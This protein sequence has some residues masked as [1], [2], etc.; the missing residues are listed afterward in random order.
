[1]IETYITFYDWFKKEI[2]T[3]IYFLNN[4]LRIYWCKLTNFLKLNLWYYKSVFEK[5]IKLN[6]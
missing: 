5:E 3:F 6:I 4:A 1:M 2:L